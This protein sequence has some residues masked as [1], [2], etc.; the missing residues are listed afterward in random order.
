VS[1]YLSVTFVNSVKTSIVSSEFFHIG[2][3]TVLEYT[4]VTDRHRGLLTDGRTDTM[5]VQG[6]E[7]YINQFFHIGS[8]TVLEYT[9]VTDRHRGLLTDGYA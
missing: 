1:V 8:Q 3:Q 5:H 4:N 6:G 2:S 9:N 7:T